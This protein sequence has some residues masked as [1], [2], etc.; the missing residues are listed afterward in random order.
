MLYDFARFSFLSCYLF[1]RSLAV[2]KSHTHFSPFIYIRVGGWQKQ[3]EDCDELSSPFC[4]ILLTCEAADLGF[5]CHIIAY[6]Y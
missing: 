6:V 3:K 2:E 5:L 4:E 1:V